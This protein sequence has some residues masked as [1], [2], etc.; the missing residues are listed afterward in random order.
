MPSPS[1]DAS[2]IAVIRARLAASPRPADL[3]ARRARVDA[4]G[5]GYGLPDDVAVQPEKLRDV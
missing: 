3:A 2:E 1:V 5:A 4:L